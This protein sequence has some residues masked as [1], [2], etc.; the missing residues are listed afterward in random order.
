MAA[1]EIFRTIPGPKQSWRPL[2]VHIDDSRRVR[3]RGAGFETVDAEAGP[4]HLSVYG[5]DHVRQSIEVHVA[6]NRPTQVLVGPGAGGISTDRHRVDI[7]ECSDKEDL[8]RCLIP[9]HNPGG[10][11]QTLA[12]GRNKA[13]LA[14]LMM[15]GT[16][17]FLVA[18]GVLFLFDAKFAVQ[19]LFGLVILGIG[20]WIVWRLRI[21]W[22]SI[23]N[24]RHWPM[25]DWRVN[26]KVGGSEEWKRWSSASPDEWTNLWS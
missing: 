4:H 16:G 3:I 12:Q 5:A 15:L 14:F 1:I 17:L 10:L 26:D 11:P 7:K 20:A 18:L 21:V 13:W 24:Q 19:Y 2:T 8:P 22:W 25:E 23:W 9:L 6:A